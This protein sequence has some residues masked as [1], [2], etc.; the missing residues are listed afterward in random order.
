MKTLS[1]RH[2]IPTRP[3]A[4]RFS[5]SLL[6][7]A[8]LLAAGPAPAQD[9]PAADRDAQAPARTGTPAAAQTPL[10]ITYTGNE[11]FLIAGAGKKVLVDA[12][13]REG[14]S[15]YVVPPPRQRTQMESAQ[16]PFDGIDLVLTT[17]YHGDHF[18]PEAVGTCLLSNPRAIYVSTPQAVEA[19]QGH[20]GQFVDVRERVRSVLPREGNKESVSLPGIDLRV[21]NL[22]HG[23]KR[24]VEN[25]GFLI[26]LGGRKLLHM[27][28]TE[29]TYKDLLPLRLDEAEIDVAFVPFW[30]LLDPG[31]RKAVREG[32]KPRR[33]VAMHLPEPRARDRY[34]ESLGGWDKV[35]EI[36]E[37]EFPGAVIFRDLMESRDL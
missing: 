21:M 27:G 26:V 4:P 3:R 25:L 17:H 37:A 18:H 6:A 31:W 9:A 7:G 36:I 22:H 2:R 1:T 14:V 29:A 20:F 12:L 30:L 24:P 23:R 10:T 28:D 5:A 32:I 8:L 11:G 13:Y 34:I 19:L 16:P 35:A 15:G 33:V